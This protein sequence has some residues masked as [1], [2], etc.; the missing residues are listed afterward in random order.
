MRSI[1]TSLYLAAALGFA[2]CVPGHAAAQGEGAA[3]T[4]AQGAFADAYIQATRQQ[5]MQVFWDMVHP[6]SQSC[7]S[8][9]YRELVEVEKYQTLM[10]KPIGEAYTLQAISVDREQVMSYYQD[11]YGKKVMVPVVP[12]VAIAVFYERERGLCKPKMERRF[13]FVAPDNKG[14]WYEVLPCPKKLKHTAERYRMKQLAQDAS[15]TFFSVTVSPEERE[16][17]KAIILRNNEP[18]YVAAKLSERRGV[19]QEL[20]ARLVDEICMTAAKEAEASR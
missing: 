12:P 8:K 20:A 15:Y 17:M 13:I 11:L 3:L 5:D 6:A 19:Q 16:E 7:V 1:F 4:A 9:D 2:L 10:D 18:D 14:R